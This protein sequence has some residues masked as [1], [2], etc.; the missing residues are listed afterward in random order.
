MATFSTKLVAIFYLFLSKCT[1]EMEPYV[2][3][4]DYAKIDQYPHSVFLYVENNGEAWICGASIVNQL[5]LLT[6][7]HCLEGCLTDWSVKAYAGSAHVNEMKAVRLVSKYIIHVHYDTRKSLNDI[8]LAHIKKPFPFGRTIQRVILKRNFKGVKNAKVAG[9]GLVND[10][11]E[12]DTELLKAVTQKLQSKSSCKEAGELLK[13]MMC[14]T[15]NRKNR[16]SKGDSGSALVTSDGQQIGLVSFRHPHAPELV[17]YTNVSYY[18][19]WIQHSSRMLLC[20]KKK[21]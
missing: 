5:L 19:D 1:G 8:A 17:I 3:G 2:V 4:G 14:A 11:T 20:P 12:E 10:Q 7:A 6:A 21:G 18:Y 16:P 13:G 15:N 9:W